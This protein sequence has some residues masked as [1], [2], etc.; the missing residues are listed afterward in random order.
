MPEEALERSWQ[1]RTSSRA[2]GL[3]EVVGGRGSSS[4][5]KSQVYH[6]KRVRE[7]RGKGLVPLF[8]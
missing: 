6:I 8:S 7:G 3:I 2:E 4:I 1:K 5:T